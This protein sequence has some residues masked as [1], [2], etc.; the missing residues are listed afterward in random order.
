MMQKNL[1]N[2][3]LIY[4]YGLKIPSD[5]HFFK[6]AVVI[7]VED[8]RIIIKQAP[9]VCVFCGALATL[10]VKEQGVCKKC[11]EEVRPLNRLQRWNKQK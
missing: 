3:E 9:Y 6:G 5:L 4:R 1:C 2:L 11:V 10:F 7:E 8:N